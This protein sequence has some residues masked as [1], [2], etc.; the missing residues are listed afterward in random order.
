M[1]VSAFVKDRTL[2]LGTAAAVIRPGASG[3]H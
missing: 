3:D 1:S 2:L